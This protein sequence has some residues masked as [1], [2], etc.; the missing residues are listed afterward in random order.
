MD[1]ILKKVE[2]LSIFFIIYLFFFI[3]FFST[4]KYTLPFLLAL[5]FAYILKYPTKFLI[6]KFNFKT[7]WAS[8]FTTI[9]F[10]LIIFSITTSLIVVLVSEM[11]NLTKYLQELLNFNPE[12]IL[13]IFNSIN[14]NFLIDI[15]PQIIDI[16][17]TNLISSIK[18]FVTMALNSTSSLLELLVKFLGYVPSVAIAIVCTLIST[19]FFTKKLL[20][21]NTNNYLKKTFPNKKDKIINIFLESRKNLINYLF[22]YLF[23]IFIS[24]ALTFIGFSI[25]KIDYSLFLSILAGFLDFLPILGI[26][27]VYF[28]IAIFY[29]IKGNYLL[30]FLVLALYGL[31]SFLRQII[32]PKILS[33]SLGIHP[34]ASLAAM[35]IGL[36]LNG[37]MGIIFCL[38]LVVAYNTLKKVNLL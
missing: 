10:F 20:T 14:D 38:F 2:R 27:I 33:S 25:L 15:D 19:Y 6:K 36:Q 3:L 35:F 23:I 26:A 34:V 32:E 29:F 31:I 11:I 21:I 28:P 22:A 7:W 17:K 1:L 8:L 16:I 4:L 30:G 5:I 18:T 37:F 13:N 24:T 9:I 12:D